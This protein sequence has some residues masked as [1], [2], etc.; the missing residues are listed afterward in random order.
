MQEMVR[1]CKPGGMVVLSSSSHSE[2][3]DVTNELS[4]YVCSLGPDEVSD[5]TRILC[6]NPHVFSSELLQ[7]GF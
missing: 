3:F 2:I 4:R 6:S 7:A 5:T 1:V